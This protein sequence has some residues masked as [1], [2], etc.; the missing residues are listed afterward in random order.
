MTGQLTGD[1]VRKIVREEINELKE[2]V[3][4]QGV[5]LEDLH[6]KFDKNIDLLSAELKIKTKVDIHET[7]IDGLET[8]QSLLKTTV[9]LHSRQLGATK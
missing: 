9:A 2:E 5:L 3:T 4:K 6:A 8:N 7:R 1:K